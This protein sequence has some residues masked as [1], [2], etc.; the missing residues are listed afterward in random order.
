MPKDPKGHGSEKRGGSNYARQ[1]PT[2]NGRA[3]MY[4]TSMED[5]IKIAQDQQN[6][7][8]GRSAG[9][10][11]NPLGHADAASQ[12][13]AGSGSKS[14]PVSTHDAH[15]VKE[16]EGSMSRLRDTFKQGDNKHGEYGR[17]VREAFDRHA[18]LHSKLT[19]KPKRN[20]YD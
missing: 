16:A 5:R 13:R 3:R 18:D 11:G 2:K 1:A 6:I 10:P 15:R 19:G 17:N 7:K 9:S 20:I 4:G 12:L 8:E 14:D